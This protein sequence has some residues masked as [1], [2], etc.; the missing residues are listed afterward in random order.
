MELILSRKDAK[1]QREEEYLR[2]IKYKIGRS[3]FLKLAGFAGVGVLGATTYPLIPRLLSQDDKLKTFPFDI[4]TVN[5]YGQE[6]NCR[7]GKVEYFT[8]ELGNGVTLDMVS[9]PGGQFLMGSP[10]SEEGRLNPERSQH[11][12]NVSPFFMGKYPITQSQWLAVMGNNPSHFQGSELPVENVSWEDCVNFCTKLSQLTKKEFRLSTET[13]WEYAC[14]ANTTTPFYFGPT[15]T[16]DLANYRGDYPYGLGPKGVYRKKTTKVGSF[17]PNAFGL[18]DMHG[19]VYEWCVDRF[20]NNSENG[21]I[22]RGGSWYDGPS[23]CR[24][25]FMNWGRPEERYE[26]AGLRVVCR[27]RSPLYPPLS[28]GVP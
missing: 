27:V 15:L 22:I 21:R 16:T 14:R 8:V 20:Q 3:K 23:Y 4:I 1:A 26:I 24:C 13:E 2:L 18:Y 5:E 11:L 10:E 12:V 7:P 9:I 25:A 19:N 17:P 6:I 28:R